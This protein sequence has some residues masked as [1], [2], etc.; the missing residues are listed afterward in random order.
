MGSYQVDSLLITRSMCAAF[1]NASR[2]YAA[3]GVFT[4]GQFCCLFS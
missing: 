4:F 1:S 2:R 3:L